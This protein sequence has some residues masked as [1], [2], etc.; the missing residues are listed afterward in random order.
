VAKGALKQICACKIKHT[1]AEQLENDQSIHK[2]RHSSFA[3]GTSKE[4]ELVGMQG[5]MN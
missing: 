1:F 5:K 4:L 2:I 3:N